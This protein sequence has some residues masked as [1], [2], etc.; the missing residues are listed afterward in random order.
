M[1]YQPC[2]HKNAAVYVIVYNCH[3]VKL[4]LGFRENSN[5]RVLPPQ[6]GRMNNLP[7]RYYFCTAGTWDWLILFSTHISMELWTSYDVATGK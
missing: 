3:F 2:E 1:S 6:Y 4:W 5:T 7:F